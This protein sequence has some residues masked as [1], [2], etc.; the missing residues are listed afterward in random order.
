MAYVNDISTL[1][2]S[3]IINF[4]LLKDFHGSWE[5]FTGHHSPIY[6]RTN[7]KDEQI[8]L[9]ID[10]S[11]KYWLNNGTPREKIVLGLGTYGR[12]FTLADSNKN[13][14]GARTNGPGLQMRVI[15]VLN[16]NFQILFLITLKSFKYTS[17]AGIAAYYEICSLEKGWT[18][19][20][21]T[22]QKVPYIYKGNQWIG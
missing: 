5:S 13:T 3:L 17:S 18:R 15:T 14:L 7:E 8:F 9:N 6:P 11:I 20:F 2:V 22:E 16:S 19:V 12:S 1:I 4:N 10:T 21:D